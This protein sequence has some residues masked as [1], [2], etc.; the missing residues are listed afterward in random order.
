MYC[1]LLRSYLEHRYS[2][3]DKDEFK[4]DRL[5][6]ILQE[7][8]DLKDS[9]YKIFTEVDSRQILQVYSEIYNIKNFV[10]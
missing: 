7:M 2:D 3:K 4:F 9:I 5:M 10:K 1:Q 8:S 6:K